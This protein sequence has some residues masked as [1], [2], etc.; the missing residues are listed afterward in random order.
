MQAF[1]CKGYVNVRLFL[2]PGDV[3]I[4]SQRC[5]AIQ[6]SVDEYG[7]L[8]LRQCSNVFGW[9]VWLWCMGVIVLQLAAA[10]RT[11]RRCLS[12]QNEK[13][14]HNE[15]RPSH[16]A[17]SRLLCHFSQRPQLYSDAFHKCSCCC[18]AL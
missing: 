1:E 11:P 15:D 13:R 8:Q 9:A 18:S 2:I 14:R 17:L 3:M 5:T 6:R 16:P 7:E 12:W 10:L 4:A